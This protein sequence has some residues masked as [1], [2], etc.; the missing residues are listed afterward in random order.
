MQMTVWNSVDG[1]GRPAYS[2]PWLAQFVFALDRHLQRRDGVV[3]YSREP[4]CMFRLQVC[5]SDR[6]I[7]LRDGTR[8]RIGDRI[9]RLHY[10]NEQMPLA[11]ANGANIAWAREFHRRIALSLTEL[12][13]YLAEHPELAD[14]EVICG[15]VSSGVKEQSDKVARIMARY[16]FESFPEPSL[17]LGGRVHRFGENLMISLM[18]LARN[19][20]V[21]RFASFRRVRVPIYLSRQVLQRRLVPCHDAPVVT[22]ADRS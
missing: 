8:V 18:V 19:A 22:R 13:R 12:A 21:F 11:H 4:D 14:V 2:L 17:P 3:E 5:R 20:G 6:A 9:A 7:T 16:G 10:W 1:D 15:D